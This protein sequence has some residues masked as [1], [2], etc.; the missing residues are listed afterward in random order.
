ML[1][2]AVAVRGRP[3]RR[4]PVRT[5]DSAFLLARAGMVIPGVIDIL[6]YESVLATAKSTARP[7]LAWSSPRVAAQRKSRGD[8]LGDLESPRVRGLRAERRRSAGRSA[9]APARREWPA[10][11]PPPCT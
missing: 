10:S 1:A 11:S 3:L 4:A 5:V 9:S 2:E 8:I 6:V 7:S